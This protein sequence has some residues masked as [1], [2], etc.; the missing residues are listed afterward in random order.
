MSRLQE[1][2]PKQRV[3]HTLEHSRNLEYVPIA[4]SKYE[5]SSAL[6][7]MISDLSVSRDEQATRRW[8]TNI[9]RFDFTSRNFQFPEAHS[10]IH[11]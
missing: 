11:N 3:A 8:T 7:H 10:L 5:C 9:F 6:R 1:S 4:I 2:Q